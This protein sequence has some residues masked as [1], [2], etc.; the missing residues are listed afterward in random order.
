MSCSFF[1]LVSVLIRVIPT[2]PPPPPSPETLLVTQCD[3]PRI[4]M[5]SH[6]L[7]TT[8]I[9]LKDHFLFEYN[10]NTNIIK[11]LDYGVT[12]S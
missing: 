9:I 5:G 4:W 1:E 3:G 10:T 6:P 2:S 11:Q 8:I 12:N 7:V